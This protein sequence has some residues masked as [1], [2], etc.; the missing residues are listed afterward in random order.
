MLRF[1]TFLTK[2]HSCWV[3]M[4]KSGHGLSLRAY[5]ASSAQPAPKSSTE[6]ARETKKEKKAFVT[7][8]FVMNLFNGQLKSDQVFPFPE[9]LN[10]EQ[11][12]TLQMLTDPTAKFFEEV[13]DPLKN[14]LIE[15]VEDNTMEG[16][17]EMGAFGM[18]VPQ[19]LGGVGLNNTQYAR[20]VEVV[21]KHDLG[22]GITL[23]AHQSI[24]FK[25]I[26]LYGNEA[27]KKKYLPPL[28]SGELI[29][30]YCLT[31]PESGSDAASIKTRAVLSEDETHYILNGGKI[32]ISNGGLAEIFTVFAKTP[33]KIPSGEVKEKITAFIVERGFGGVTNGPPEK[34]MGIKASNTAEVHFEDVKVPVE[35]VLGEV[36]EGFKVAMNILN[37]GRFGMAAAL[38]GTMRFAIEKATEHAVNRTQFGNKISTYGSIQEKL[39]RMAM[40]HYITESMAYMVSGNMDRGFVDFQLEAAISKIYASEAAWFVVDEAIQ[41]LGG[42]GFMRDTGLERVLRDLRIFRIFE[43]AND[44]LRLFVAL[45]GLQYAGGHLKELQK[46]MKNPAANLGLILDEGAKRMKRVVGLNNGSFLTPYVHSDLAESASKVNKTIEQFGVSV[47]NL[48]MKYGKNI[49]HEQ[50]LLN[51]LANSA[52]DIY[53][54][55]TVL[56]R[57]SRSLQQHLSSAEYEHNLTSVICSEGYER[58]QLNL[59]SLKTSEKLKNFEKMSKISQ[60]LCKHGGLV[61]QHPLGF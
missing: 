42:M 46:A 39:A 48:L 61:Q 23:G 18:Q 58:V 32:W 24:G 25:G 47:E 41:I 30:A 53:S 33:V 31:E 52:I 38:S 19:D 16:L 60:D 50:F 26:L 51:R 5:A 13:N 10:Q 36:G 4:Q 21:G 45:T 34:K 43:G 56:S 37:N 12:E 8:S 29:A 22:V 54:M 11:Q 55:V 9:V 3:M 27:Q 59:N 14:D 49:V 44:I 1:S 17:R 40:A 15:K 6:N 35:N 2:N 7:N 28:A 57:A 20:L